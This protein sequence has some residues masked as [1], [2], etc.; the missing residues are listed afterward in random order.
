MD[1]Y[2]KDV[3]VVGTSGDIISFTNKVTNTFTTKNQAYKM[4]E[5]PAETQMHAI[6]TEEYGAPKDVLQ[7]K[8]VP[9]PQLQ[10]DKVLIRVLSA[11]THAGDWHLIRG[12]PFFIRPLFGRLFRPTIHIA[13]SDICGRVE[14]IGEDVE[15][16]LT[17]GDVVFGDLSSVGFGAFAEFVTAPP[18]AV[19]RKPDNVT[20]CQA[21]ASGTSLL[22]ALHAVRD[23]AGVKATQRVLVVGASGGVGMFA[24]QLCKYYNAFVVAACRPEKAEVVGALGADHVVEYA[25]CTEV[26]KDEAHMPFDAV[27]DAACFRSPGDYA[28]IM[29]PGGTYVLVGGS[30][31]RFLQG[32]LVGRI[33]SLVKGIV[34]K[35]LES[36]PN[37]KD[38]LFIHDLLKDGHVVPHIDRTFDLEQTAEAIH[39]V[40]DRKVTGKVTIRCSSLPET[41]T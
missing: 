39:Y 17:V 3:Y 38:L 27:I 11:S 16:D 25:S 20:P 1:P 10:Q 29:K 40:E 2:I 8:M 32:M 26:G 31:A 13:G 30:T 5:T 18:T 21:A 22:A 36:M 24:V 14:A 9:K 4:S 6:Y 33:L 7:F 12:T 15:S 19:V 28:R 41:H 23:L 34:V 37:P 35:S